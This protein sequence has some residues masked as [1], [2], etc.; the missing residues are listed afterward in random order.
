MKQSWHTRCLIALSFSIALTGCGFRDIDKRFFVV[1]M[2]IDQADKPGHFNLTLK[3]AVPE[4]EPQKK[5]QDSITLS[6]EAASISEA[7]RKIM[8]KVNLKLDFGQ[9]K[10]VIFGERLAKEDLTPSLDWLMRRRDIEY[11]ALLGIGS[12]DAASIIRKEGK[13]EGIPS[14]ALLKALQE[15]TAGSNMITS[16]QLFEFYRNYR[17]KGI[18]PALPVITLQKESFQINRAAIFKKQESLSAKGWLTPSETEIYNLLVNRKPYMTVH[19]QHSGMNFIM[20]VLRAR[21]AYAIHVPGDGNPLIKVDVNIEGI[22]EEALN[23]VDEKQLADYQHEAE[24]EVE[25]RILTYLE[26]MRDQQLDPVGFGLRYRSRHLERSV[27]WERWV[28]MYPEIEIQVN[29]HV[30]LRNT[31]LLKV[32][33]D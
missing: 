1:S 32:S 22:I 31:G 5:Q 15:S 9:M 11:I 23:P 30:K 16:V 3:M 33:H 6:A 14:N 12:P 20:D 2:G 24:Q 21:T 8:A 25:N 29:P 18:S 17:A 13:I 4:S 27:E 28:S 19:V 7:V 10:A 26:R